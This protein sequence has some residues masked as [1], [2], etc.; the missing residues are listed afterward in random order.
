MDYAGTIRGEQAEDARGK[1]YAIE[2]VKIRYS[3]EYTQS[4]RQLQVHA[5]CTI[6]QLSAFEKHMRQ[7]ALCQA[8]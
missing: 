5:E 8:P 6:G 3:C 7:G 1:Q 4:V 2:R